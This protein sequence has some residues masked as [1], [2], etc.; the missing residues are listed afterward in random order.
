MANHRALSPTRA[1][2]DSRERIATFPR[3]RLGLAFGDERLRA[4]MFP[5]N[6]DAPD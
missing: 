2:T 6:L 5:P 3:I 1:L 4:A